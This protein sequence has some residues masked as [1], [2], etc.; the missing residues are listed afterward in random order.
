LHI[1]QNEVLK[2]KAFK[3]AWTASDAESEA[4]TVDGTG[5]APT[6]TI[7]PPTG[8]T[9]LASDDL[10]ILV[11]AGDSDGTVEKIELFQN[12]IKV[13][14]STGSVLRFSLTKVF[15]GSS[16]FTAK[17]YDDWGL[18]G[19]D[20]ATITVSVSGP[21]VSLA[22]QQPFVSLS[23]SGLSASI[24]GVDPESLQ[25]MTLNG[26]SFVPKNRLVYHA[27]RSF[28]SRS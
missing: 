12:G 20:S 10:N 11:Q 5:S 25:S 18:V 27:G 7:S 4:Y 21:V 24:V 26:S 19:T 23:P 3:D 1:A 17:A 28:H 22:P 13:A 15:S 14:E 2:A 16:A 9:V 8:T 6:V